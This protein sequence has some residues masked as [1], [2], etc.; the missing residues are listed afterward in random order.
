MNILK[1]CRILFKNLLLGYKKINVSLVHLKK[2]NIRIKYGSFINYK[3][4]E[5]S[6][7]KS[8]GKFLHV[9]LE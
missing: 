6:A 1:K 2:M 9:I 4:E 5:E 8:N 3:L 7:R